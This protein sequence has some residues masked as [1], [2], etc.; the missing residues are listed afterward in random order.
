MIKTFLKKSKYNTDIQGLNQRVENAE[1]KISDVSIL[2]TNTAFNTKIGEV[3]N[4]IQDVNRL[5]TDTGFST[6]IGE[7]KNKNTRC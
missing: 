3:E 5:A 2:V 1:N 6:K 7:G 4:K